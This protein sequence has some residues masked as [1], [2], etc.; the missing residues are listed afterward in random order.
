MS[1]PWSVFSRTKSDG[2]YLYAYARKH[3]VATGHVE[4]LNGC[5][6][7][8]AVGQ[9]S[10]PACRSQRNSRALSATAHDVPLASEHQYKAD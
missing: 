4:F 5:N 9:A 6:A 2:L 7:A 3:L 8:G 1:N 10:Q